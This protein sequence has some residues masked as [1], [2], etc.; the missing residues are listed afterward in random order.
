[1]PG[2]VKIGRTSHN[3][4]NI[5]IAQLYTTGV[6]VPFTLE[7]ANR[8]QNAAEVEQAMHTAFGPYRINPKR[9][10]FRIDPEQ[11]KCL[12]DAASGFHK[13]R[14]APRAT[15]LIQDVRVCRAGTVR[16]S[17]TMA[18]AVLIGVVHEFHCRS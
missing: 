7:F 16:Q 8:V 3:D 5:R 11:A 18:V 2:L 15:L 17:D 14:E 13:K 4:A 10:F 9:E 6:P 12:A 1:M